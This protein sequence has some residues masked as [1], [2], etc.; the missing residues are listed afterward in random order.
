MLFLYGRVRMPEEEVVA[1]PGVVTTG[2][3]VEHLELR[4]E[5]FVR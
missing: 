4:E 3:R 2:G 5:V 1:S